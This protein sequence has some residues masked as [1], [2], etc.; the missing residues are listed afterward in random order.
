MISELYAST[1]NSTVSLLILL[2][3]THSRSLVI[4]WKRYP[5]ALRS[6][7]YF[8]PSLPSCSC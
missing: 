7:L 8:S 6:C 2:T 4:T 5:L 1:T 3:Q